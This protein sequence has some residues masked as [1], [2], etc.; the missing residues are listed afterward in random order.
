M[1]DYRGKLATI[2]F[3]FP[4]LLGAIAPR[5]MFVNAPLHDG[6]FRAKSVDR[7]VSAARPVYELL[8]GDGKLIVRHPDCDH[9]FP[10]EMREQAYAVIDSVLQGVSK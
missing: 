8:G 1:T 5:A 6:N 2:P 7:C 9:D 10:D 4:E 3:D